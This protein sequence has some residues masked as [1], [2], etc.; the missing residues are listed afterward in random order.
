MP[1]IAGLFGEHSLAAITSAN[2]IHLMDH[3]QLLRQ[4]GR[5]FAP[6]RVIAVLSNGRPPD[7]GFRCLVLLAGA[8]VPG[9]ADL[10]VWHRPEVPRPRRGLKAAGNADVREKVPVDYEDVLDL[11]QISECG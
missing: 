7:R 3:D 4:A 9:Q 10:R 5:C 2:S 8:P 1:G 11:D 6:A